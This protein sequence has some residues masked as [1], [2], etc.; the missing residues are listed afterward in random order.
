MCPI[1][2]ETSAPRDPVPEG[3][4]P[5]ICYAVVDL[6]MQQPLPG[7]KFQ[8]GPSHKVLLMFEL[9]DERIT[10]D[11]NGEQRDMPR[12]LSK[13]FT[14]S[15]HEKA[16]L[17]KF[18][19]SWRGR[20]F[21][22][23]E[24]QG[25]DLKNVLGANSMINVVHKDNGYE[26]ITGCMKLPKGM[27]TRQSENALVLYDIDQPIP[28]TLPDWVRNKIARSEEHERAIDGGN[29]P[30]PPGYETDDIPFIYNAGDFGERP[31]KG[32]RWQKW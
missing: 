23:E 3:T 10:I 32:A 13:E 4:H 1:A 9:P 12:A 30:P 6:G 28:P 22:P 27:P 8:K 15:L 16:G 20:Q 19:V 25:F 24:L 26:D 14:L 29:P 11:K 7:S 17:R 18:L 2:K 21:T 31:I 5:A